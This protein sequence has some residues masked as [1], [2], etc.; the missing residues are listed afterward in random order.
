M[1]QYEDD[2]SVDELLEHLSAVHGV[3]RTPLIEHLSRTQGATRT[4]VYLYHWLL[5]ERDARQRRR[6]L[7]RILE[8][9]RR[10]L[11]LW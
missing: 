9:V 11:G 7:T 1:H 10:H 8:F 6:V 5:H 2:L 4:P 3:E